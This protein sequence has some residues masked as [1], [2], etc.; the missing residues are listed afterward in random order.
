MNE[1]FD[2]TIIARLDSDGGP[3]TNHAGVQDIGMALRE[4][5]RGKSTLGLPLAPHGA[6]LMHREVK[7]SDDNSG[8]SC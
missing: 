2:E 8:E 1:L 7:N 3:K 6:I 5:K 4:H